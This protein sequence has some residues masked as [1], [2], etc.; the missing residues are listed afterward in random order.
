MVT[1][2]EARLRV[3]LVALDSL[4]AIYP[5]DMKGYLDGMQLIMQALYPNGEVDK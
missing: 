2:A 5:D 1:T 3:L 4:R